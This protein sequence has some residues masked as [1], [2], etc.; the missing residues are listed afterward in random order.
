MTLMISVITDKAVLQVSDRRLIWL[1]ADGSTR[2]MNDNKNKAVV[3]GKRMVFA[4]TGLA[5]LGPRRQRT[6]EWLAEEIRQAIQGPG[7]QDEI[8][9]HIARKATERLQHH[10]CASLPTVQRGHEFVACGWAHFLDFEPGEFRP[11]V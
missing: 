6:D 5:N 8:L 3:F 9:E 1:E 4:Y 11:Y 2:P 7:S 10:L